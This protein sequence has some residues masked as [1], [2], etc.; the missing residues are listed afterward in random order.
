M[1]QKPQ[2]VEISYRTIVFT[3]LFLVSLSLLWQLRS[4]LIL[5]FFCFIFM[6]AI[7]PAVVRLERYRLS[8]PLAII[9]LYLIILAVF[10]FA[11]AG[12]IPILV[13]QTSSL[14]AAFPDIIKNTTFLGA[15][16]I[17]I[18]SQFKIIESLPAN[19]AKTAVSL[20]SN[21]FSSFVIF[22]ISF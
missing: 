5:F 8:R 4:L 7:N 14:I 15:S 10:S 21:I 17:D 11:V 20:F 22:V 12:V 9:L 2:R 1:T 16:A 13:E 18:S 19:I 6:E 3:V